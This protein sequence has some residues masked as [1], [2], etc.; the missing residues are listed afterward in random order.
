MIYPFANYIVYA[1]LKGLQL[2]ARFY[3]RSSRLL[4]L[5]IMGQ[6]VSH[7]IFFRRSVECNDDAG[8]GVD[9]GSE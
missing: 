4:A 2:S 3:E 1:R 8:A 5:R 6:C 9:G 7:Y